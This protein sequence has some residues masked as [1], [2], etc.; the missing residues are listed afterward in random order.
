MRWLPA[1]ILIHIQ[2]FLWAQ[3]GRAGQLPPALKPAQ[4]DDCVPVPDTHVQTVLTLPGWLHIKDGHRPRE[5]S[6]GPAKDIAAG[7]MQG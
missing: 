2:H 1:L 6:Q 7:R 3:R 4:R 5:C